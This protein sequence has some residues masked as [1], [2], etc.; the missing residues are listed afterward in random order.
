MM[1]PLLFQPNM[2][3][4]VWGGDRLQPY[5][6]LAITNDPIGESWEV[7]SIE[8]SPSII[9][10][11]PLSG[12][13]LPEAISIHKE[14]IL[15]EEVTNR[16]E[17]KMPLLVKI[18]DAK[19][20]LSIQVHPN[21]EMA[22]REHGKFGKTEMWYIIDAEPG[23]SLYAGF[24][25]EIT[26]YEYSKRIEDGTICDV[27]AKHNVHAGDVFYIPAGRVHAI[28]GGVLLAEVQQS[29]DITYRIFD[30]NRLGLDGKPRQL[31]TSKALQAINFHVEED[32]RT[33]YPSTSE[34]AVSIIDTPYFDVR[35]MNVTQPFHRNLMKYDSFVIS[36]CIKGECRIRLREGEFVDKDNM[37]I[38]LHEG[39]SC[40]IPACVADYDIIPLCEKAKIL[41]THIDNKDRSLPARVTRFLHITK[42]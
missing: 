12:L 10:N 8:S 4:T 2:H 20:N 35:L 13:S 37:E 16:Y 3:I 21:D 9:A 23:A 28:C 5:K 14:Q 39:N 34:R 22:M 24:K 27:L 30:Y 38:E 7:S 41:E 1:Y 31:H 40:L 6:K 15:G 36:M 11:G 42:K 17:G 33:H 26:P 19:Q 25:K 18:I 29:S 32:Y